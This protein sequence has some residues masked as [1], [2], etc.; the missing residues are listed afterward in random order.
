[1]TH[2]YGVTIGDLEDA[3]G[4]GQAVVFKEDALGRE[5]AEFADEV[6]SG[7]VAEEAAGG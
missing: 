2:E 4:V 5:K 1:M 3:R 6:W 7:F